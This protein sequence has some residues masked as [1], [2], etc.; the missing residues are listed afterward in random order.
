LDG[1]VERRRRRLVGHVDPHAPG[2]ARPTGCRWGVIGRTGC[3]WRSLPEQ[4]DRVDHRPARDDRRRAAAAGRVEQV[5]HQFPLLV[6]Q[7]DGT[8]T[9]IVA[10]STM[11]WRR[12]AGSWK[13]ALFHS[14]PL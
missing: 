2:L 1:S 6:G 11:I 3:Q 12:V 13:V 8:Q 5:G 4:Q 9:Q 10:P 14:I 7:G